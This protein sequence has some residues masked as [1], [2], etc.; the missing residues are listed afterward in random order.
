MANFFSG[1][2]AQGVGTSNSWVEN[3]A[4]GYARQSCT[5]NTLYPG[6]SALAIGVTFPAISTAIV[7]TQRALYD[8][9]SGGNLVMWWTVS[10][11]K[12]VSAQTTDA[13]AAGELM[14][15]Y[16]DI[17]EFN[18]LNSLVW[19]PGSRIGTTSSNKAIYAGATAGYAAGAV[20]AATVLGL[21][22][23]GAG[24]SFPGGTGLTGAT[25]Q[26]I[27]LG[28]GLS[29]SGSVLNSSGGGSY[30]FS[31]GLSN[32]N[33]TI[34]VNYGTTSG[35][36]AQGND[37]RLGLAATALQP[38]ALPATSQLYGGTSSAGTA[39]AI[40]VG[41]GLTL[42]G[43]TLSNSGGGASFPGGTGLSSATGTLVTVST[44]LSLSGGVLTA[45][46][47][48]GGAPSS[49]TLFTPALYI[50]GGA[51]GATYTTQSGRYLQTGALTVF[52]L[53][54]EWSAM[55]TAN[56]AITIT[57]LPGAV[58]GGSGQLVVSGYGVT[59]SGPVYGVVNTSG[60][61]TLLV[62]GSGA[63]S[64]DP[65]LATTNLASVGGFVVCG[66]YFTA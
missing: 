16:P 22:G 48:G 12:T 15:T 36:A 39:V 21:G 19:A 14:H 32:S 44:G 1:Y 37:S 25:G 23:T 17:A 13:L 29:F 43:T 53:D 49:S 38:S 35:T 58:S 41:S 57:G 66:S 45:T 31:T 61:L 56:G 47:G 28:T 52:D 5:L 55:G 27:T 54:V 51:S 30:T 42:S 18:G 11:G 7:V 20:G 9:S 33:G 6:T 2:L 62:G 26:L 8:A 10:S 3:T 34:T 50:A 46:G 4:S 24:V 65:A 40:T 63:A 59:A 60:V 64:T